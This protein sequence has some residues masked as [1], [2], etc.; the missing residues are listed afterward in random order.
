M[1]IAYNLLAANEQPGNIK[2]H[3]GRNTSLK[4]PDELLW[5]QELSNSLAKWAS[6]TLAN[7]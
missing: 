6:S 1:I 3:F 5:E 2:M 4:G 7:C